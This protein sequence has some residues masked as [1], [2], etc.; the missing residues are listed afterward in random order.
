MKEINW[1]PCFV[2]PDMECDLVCL[3]C[4]CVVHVFLCLA[5]V[6]YSNSEGQDMEDLSVGP[7]VEL[8]EEIRSISAIMD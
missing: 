7:E 4:S 2:C 8:F 3:T 1:E 6:T 5:W